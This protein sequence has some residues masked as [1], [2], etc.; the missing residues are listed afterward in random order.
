M[1]LKYKSNCPFCDI[2]KERTRIID[3]G[4]YVRIILSNP[5]LMYGHLLVVPKRHV[6]RMSELYE[7][8]RSELISKVIEFQE[9]ILN[10]LANGCDLRQN[11]RPFQNQTNLK[12][13]HLHIHLQPRELED[14]LYSECQRFETQIFS[15]L[16]TEEKEKLSKLFSDKNQ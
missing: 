11:Y 1:D 8:E 15:E 13:Y 2:N 14:E 9:K 10:L 3:E 7:E 12:V 4:L 6:E 16:K 5:R